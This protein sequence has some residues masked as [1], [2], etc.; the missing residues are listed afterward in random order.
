MKGYCRTC[1]Y[2][3]GSEAHRVFCGG[4]PD[5]RCTNF[6]RWRNHICTQA[7]PVSRFAW[8]EGCLQRGAYAV[9]RLDDV[10]V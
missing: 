5:L 1:G 4:E 3:V 8:C 10:R 9:A 2:G 6:E 7:W